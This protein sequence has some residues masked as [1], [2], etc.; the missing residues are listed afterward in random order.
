ML[1]FLYVLKSDR[2]LYECSVYHGFNTF[3]RKNGIFELFHPSCFEY[4]SHKSSEAQFIR[5]EDVKSDK[6][7]NAS[8]RVK[9]H[10]KESVGLLW[11]IWWSI[12]VWV[13]IFCNRPLGGFLFSTFDELQ[14]YS[15]SRFDRSSFF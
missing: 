8:L 15:I 9:R 10:P 5:A 13:S 2:V 3:S 11:W 1:E 12:E 4:L 14:K 7:G 6:K